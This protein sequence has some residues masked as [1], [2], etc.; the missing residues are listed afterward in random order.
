MAGT[1]LKP[2]LPEVGA[3]IDKRDASEPE[4]WRKRRLRAVKLA[5]KGESTSAEIADLC[6]VNRTH[7]LVWLRRVREEGLDAL[8]QRDKPG[9]KAGQLPRGEAG[10]H[11]GA[12][13]AAGGGRICQCRA[14]APLA[15]KGTR[16]GAALR[17]R[18]ELARKNC[19]E[20]CGCR[21]PVTPR[22]TPTRRRRSKASWRE[23]LKLLESRRGAV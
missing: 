5:A 1:K 2:G 22:K 16:S 12:E 19:T 10:S 17:K 9:R 14:G 8:R 18:L 11:R 20:C 4:G 3:N 7:R 13:G 6:G 23:S 15:E 21:G